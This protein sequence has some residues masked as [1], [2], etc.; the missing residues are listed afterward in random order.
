M[1]WSVNDL[2]SITDLLTTQL[3][4][5]VKASPMYVHHNFP[6][7]V[8]GLMP[9]VSRTDG[10]NVMSLYLLHVGRDPYWRNT[11]VQGQR[12]QLN[13]SQP[14][15]L[16]LSYLLTTYADKNWQMEQYLMSVA[17]SYFHANPIYK[18]ATAE[19]TVTVEADSIE[20]MSRLW[21]AITVPI[22]LSAMFRV[23]VVFLT[24]AMPPPA[25]ARR[26]DVASLSVGADLNAPGPVPEPE[27]RLFEVALQLAYRVPPGESDPTQVSLLPGPPVAV[28][29]GSVRARGS[30]LDGVDAS[31]VFLSVP[32]GA[33]EWPLLPTWR[34]LGTS[35]SGTAGDADELVVRL[36]GAYGPLPASGAT[37]TATPPPGKYLIAV[38]NSGTGF[39]SNTLPV[40]IAPRVD[41]IGPGDPVLQPDG[42][43]VYT[44]SVS[45]LAAAGTTVLLE[46]VVLTNGAAPAPGVAKIDVATGTI[47]WML[48]SPPGFPSGSYVR[49]RVV[50]TAIEAPPGWWV[51][52]P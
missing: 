39:R 13:T 48:S 6:F 47:S 46:T 37:L 14:L 41:G 4:N 34:T 29:G 23:A 51:Q 9:A 49:V 44:M 22:R 20:E 2:T 11:P 5:A 17:L 28:G 18:S 19:F 38:G 24:P 35:A 25:D 42:A 32:G 43:K 10:T 3:T 36:A 12:G 21:Q 50:V 33:S 52:I 40:T 1:A 8:S 7:D 27:P 31:S 15:S 45:G 26:A 30:G 16:N